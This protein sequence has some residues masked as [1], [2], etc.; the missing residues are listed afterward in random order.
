MLSK[1]QVYLLFVSWTVIL[2][3]LHL[4]PTYFDHKLTVFHF[5]DK[6]IHCGIFFTESFLFFLYLQK[7]GQEPNLTLVS[8]IFLSGFFLLEVLQIPIPGRT[9]DLFDILFDCFGALIGYFVVEKRLV[10]L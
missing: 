8:F 6:L 10:K 9:F 4:Y 2:I 1:N 7:S 3:V 5:E